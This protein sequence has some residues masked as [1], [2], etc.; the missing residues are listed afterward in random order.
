M[1]ENV[2]R[3]SV[4][5]ESVMRESVMRKVKRRPIEHVSRLTS[6]VIQDTRG[7]WASG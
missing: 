3:E 2:M 4:M 1:R 6:H 7:R 5:R